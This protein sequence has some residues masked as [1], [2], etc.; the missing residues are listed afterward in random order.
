MKPT[1]LLRGHKAPGAGGAGGLQPGTPCQDQP[2]LGPGVP[3]GPAG[4]GLG[5]SAPLDRL[6]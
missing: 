3:P 6:S 4:G 5:V 1:P 2:S